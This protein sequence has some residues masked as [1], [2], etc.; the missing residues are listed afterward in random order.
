MNSSEQIYAVFDCN[1]FLQ[2][3]AKKGSPANACYRLVEV[4]IVKL[5]VSKDVLAELEDVLNRPYLKERFDALTDESIRAFSNSIFEIAIIV[6]NVPKFSSLPREVDDEPYINSAIES[7]AEFIV[8]RDND[9]LDLMTGYDD[10]SKEFR[11]RFRPLKIVDP[12]E[13]LK[14]VKGKTQ[15]DLSVKP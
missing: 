15:K 11:Q 8:T 5:F 6:K 9:L 3:I 2:A 7:K 13:F 1:T 4:G 10:S 12:I 14:I